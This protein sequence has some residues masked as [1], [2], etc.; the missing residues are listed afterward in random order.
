M[1]DAVRIGEAGWAAA[2]EW[3]RGSQVW[4]TRVGVDLPVLTNRVTVAVQPT[5]E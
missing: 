2:M 4:V 1:S 5:A 3:T